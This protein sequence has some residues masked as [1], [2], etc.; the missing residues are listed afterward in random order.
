MSS[1]QQVTRLHMNTQRIFYLRL[2]DADDMST[3]TPLKLIRV[4]QL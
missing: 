1:L 2:Q 3:K 4:M